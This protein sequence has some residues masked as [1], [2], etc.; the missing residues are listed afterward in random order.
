MSAVALKL[1]FPTL[2]PESPV[3]LAQNGAISWSHF[4][5]QRYPGLRPTGLRPTG[6]RLASLNA[7]GNA[8]RRMPEGL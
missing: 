6:L 5:A 8:C 1:R 7:N 2:T 3:G 4:C